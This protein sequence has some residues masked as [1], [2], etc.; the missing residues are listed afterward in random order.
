[1]IDRCHLS[2]ARVVQLDEL[3]GSQQ[4]TSGGLPYADVKEME[5]GFL[6]VLLHCFK[7]RLGIGPTQKLVTALHTCTHTCTHM[8]CYD[9]TSGMCRGSRRII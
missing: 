5:V 2:K 8:G 3:E 6:V 1:M 9:I 4:L 7:L